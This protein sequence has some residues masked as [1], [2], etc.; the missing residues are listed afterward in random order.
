L[1]GI[2]MVNVGI[3]YGLLVYFM[4]NWYNIRP[5]G[6]VCGRLVYFSRF[7]LLGPKNLATLQL[8]AKKLLS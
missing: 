6:T 8:A 4:T 3:F 5:F 2:E 1:E 7:G